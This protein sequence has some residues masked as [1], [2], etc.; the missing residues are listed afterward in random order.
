MRYGRTSANKEFYVW[1]KG[2]RF[3][4]EQIVRARIRANALATYAMARG[5]KTIDCDAVLTS[6]NPR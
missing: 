4:T 2:Q 6:H 5:L 3:S 1:V